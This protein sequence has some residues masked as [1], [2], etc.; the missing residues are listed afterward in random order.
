MAKKFVFSPDDFNQY[1]VLK[2]PSSLYLMLIYLNKYFLLVVLPSIGAGDLSAIVK[3]FKIDLLMM[4][5]CFPAL[6]VLIAALYR[7]PSPHKW[8]KPVWKNGGF[9]LMIS[10]AMDLIILSI[11]IVL[12][13]RIAD[14]PLIALLA[15]NVGIIIYLLRSAYIK[16]M[17]KEFPEEVAK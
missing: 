8:A 10:S 7:I 1:N 5:S 13:R 16:E 3:W 15:I 4:T 6:A 14:T 12:E 11:Y 9:L 2:I 17:F